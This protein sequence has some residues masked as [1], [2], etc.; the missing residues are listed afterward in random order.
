MTLNLLKPISESG[1]FLFLSLESSI[2]IQAIIFLRSPI[3]NLS[4]GAISGFH[5]LQFYARKWIWNWNIISLKKFISGSSLKSSILDSFRLESWIELVDDVLDC[6][7]PLGV[8]PATPISDWWV[9]LK[10]KWSFF[11]CSSGQTTILLYRLGQTTKTQTKPAGH[12]ESIPA[13]RVLM[14]RRGTRWTTLIPKTQSVSKYSGIFIT[15]ISRM[16]S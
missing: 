16:R 1:E 2:Q 4:F 13:H 8:K 7:I 12:E 10:Q 6:W 14:T 5:F 11:Y 3:P 9:I 15:K